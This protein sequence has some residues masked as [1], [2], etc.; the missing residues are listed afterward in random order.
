MTIV[1]EATRL[2]PSSK[3]SEMWHGYKI[4]G[5]TSP[6]VSGFSGLFYHFFA[7]HFPIVFSVDTSGFVWVKHNS[8]AL[9]AS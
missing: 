1:K 9:K 3:E 8:V 6:L 2:S 4:Y 7:L 5:S